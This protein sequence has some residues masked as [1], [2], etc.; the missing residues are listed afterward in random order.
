MGDESKLHL[1]NWNQ[2]CCPLRSDGLGIQ[3]LHKFNQAFLRKWLWRYANESEALWYKIIKAKYEDQ[4][5]GWCT[6][7]SSSHDVGLWKHIRQGWNF[8]AN[9]IRF[10]VGMGSK[11]CF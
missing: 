10:E 2:V 3:K 6:E 8:F 1:V 11:V 7:V 5:G 9:G 4:D